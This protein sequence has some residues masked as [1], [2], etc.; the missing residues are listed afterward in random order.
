[1]DVEYSS[2]NNNN[3]DDNNQSE[4]EY[5]Y[6]YSDDGGTEGSRE[7]YDMDAASLEMEGDDDNAKDSTNNS[8]KRKSNCRSSASSA[9]S[10]VNDYLMRDNGESTLVLSC[11]G[12]SP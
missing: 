8:K 7:S 10:G 4:E 1:M 6:M 11:L 5:E 2:N 9:L 12:L 3:D